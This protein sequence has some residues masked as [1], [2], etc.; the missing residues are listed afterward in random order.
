MKKEIQHSAQSNTVY[1][2]GFVG[3]AIYFMAKAT[4]FKMGVIG[5]LKAIVWPAYFVYESFKGFGL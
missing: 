4:T 2:L 5:L 3:A 1:A